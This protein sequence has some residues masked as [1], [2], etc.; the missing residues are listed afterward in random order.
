MSLSVSS[1]QYGSVLVELHVIES[2]SCM[3]HWL[4]TF[5]SSSF[6]ICCAL[7]LCEEISRYL[8]LWQSLSLKALWKCCRWNK[9]CDRHPLLLCNNF[10]I[11]SQEFYCDQCASISLFSYAHKLEVFKNLRKC[12]MRIPQIMAAVNSNL[13]IFSCG[14]LNFE[15][16]PGITW[17]LCEGRALNTHYSR[18]DQLYFSNLSLG[19]WH[20][21]R[22]FLSLFSLCYIMYKSWN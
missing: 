15:L 3:V 18:A 7:C 9:N 5:P 4:F 20:N 13:E 21:G 1:A 2:G 8:S 6:K 22:R 19:R 17:A 12:W 14:K 16:W 11:C 10:L